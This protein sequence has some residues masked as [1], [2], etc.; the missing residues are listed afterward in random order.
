[1][2]RVL[3]RGLLLIA[4]LVLLGYLIEL[5]SL[6]SLLDKGWI[7]SEVRGKGMA[8]ELLF[9]AAGAVFSGVGLPRQM[10]AFLGGYAFGFLAGSLFGLVAVVLG[11]IATF[12]YARLFGRAL[13]LRRF[14]ERIRKLDGFIH[15]HTLTMTLLIRLLPVGSNLM[16]NLAA[17]V[18]SVRAPLFFTG[19]ALGYVPQTVVFALIGSGIAVEP[20]LRIGL[21]VVLFVVSAL[22]GVHLYRRYRRGKTLGES[23]E[24]RLED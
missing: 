4:T 8:G 6:G 19:S 5:S 22:L 14:P 7:D 17:G 16:T 1:M 18:S 13:V 15:D 23:I 24:G 12:Y 9:V 2:L 21:G 20:N 10:V 11:C 3:L